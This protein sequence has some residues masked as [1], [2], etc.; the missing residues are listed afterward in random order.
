MGERK[1]VYRVMVGKPEGK[2]HLQD[3][4]IDGRII[5]L[6]IFKKWDGRHGLHRS[7]SG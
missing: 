2:S 7:G 3:P 4:G 6:W 1:G 5:L